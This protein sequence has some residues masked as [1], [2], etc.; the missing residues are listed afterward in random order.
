MEHFIQGHVPLR[1]LLL[2]KQ[3]IVESILS[4]RRFT[5]KKSKWFGPYSTYLYEKNQFNKNKILDFVY[6][7]ILSF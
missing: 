6:N 2:I 3:I 4:W 1:Y 7:S 5:I